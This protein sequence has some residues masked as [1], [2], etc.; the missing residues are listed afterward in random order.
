[1]VCPYCKNKLEKVGLNRCPSCGGA[2][3][4]NAEHT[5][6]HVKATYPEHKMSRGI[7]EEHTYMKGVDVSLS[8]EYRV[9]VLPEMREVE[10]RTECGRTVFNTGDILGYRAFLLK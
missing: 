6:F 3:T 2:L 8:G 4:R 1:M 9:F 5:V 10:S 7:I